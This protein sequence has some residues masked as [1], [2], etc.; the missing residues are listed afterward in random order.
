MNSNCQ[1]IVF[2]S[3]PRIVG[4][5]TTAGE[6]EGYGNFG[7]Y[8]DYVLK[9]DKFGEDTFEKAERKILLHTITKAIDSAN[10][11]IS[12]IDLIVGGD[13]LNQ[14]IS[15]SFS[16]RELGLPYIGLYGACSTMAESL[17]IGATMIE[18]KHFKNIVCATGTHFSSV[19][20]QYRY[21]L[22]LGNQ[23]PPVSQWTVTG[24]GCTILSANNDSNMCISMGTIGKVEDYG[25]NDVNKEL[26]FEKVNEDKYV[27][28]YRFIQRYKGLDVVNTN[29][30]L[31][32]DKKTHRAELLNSMFVPN[33]QI[34]II[35]D[36]SDSKVKEIVEEKHFS[37]SSIN[38]MDNE[39]LTFGT[40]IHEYLE[41]IDFNNCLTSISLSTAKFAP[42]IIYT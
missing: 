4:C 25:I 29:I 35:P 20:R 18:S 41:Y 14:I 19:E 13:L 6:K 24:A 39:L 9:D 31:I 30:S 11:S 37:H 33:I 26:V 38:L 16:A 32:V 2:K 28:A 22:E 12:N 8:F 3:K 10:M 36:I 1:T 23:R 34:D 15:T 17:I 5:Y 7:K 40:K 27:Y 42:S 21:P